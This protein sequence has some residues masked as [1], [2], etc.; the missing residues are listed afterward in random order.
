MAHRWLGCSVASLWCLLWARKGDYLPMLNLAR[1]IVS[2]IMLSCGGKR[3]FKA[4]I[5]VSPRNL[6]KILSQSK[7]ETES[8]F[9]AMWLEYT[10]ETHQD[11]KTE[12]VIYKKKNRLRHD[13]PTILSWARDKE[14]Q[15]EKERSWTKLCISL[16]SAEFL[17][18]SDFRYIRRAANSWWVSPV[19]TGFLSRS[20][21]AGIYGMWALKNALKVFIKLKLCKTSRV[22]AEREREREKKCSQGEKEKPA[23][24]LS[25]I[26]A[27][28]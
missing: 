22:N 27:D 21:W 13:F 10:M 2:K 15:R 20:L 14:G 25:E 17:N 6:I 19:L 7:K 26:G 23:L 16:Q 18:G 12:I 28:I 3:P 11:K 4:L 5:A 1:E 8:G 9:L 24:F